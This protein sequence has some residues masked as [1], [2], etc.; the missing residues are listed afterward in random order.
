MK[1]EP[2]KQRRRL[3]DAGK[4]RLAA[5]PARSWQNRIGDA[6]ARRVVRALSRV[7]R[8]TAWL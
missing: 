3:Q 8:S 5:A 4:R 1:Q 7:R 2:R 6:V